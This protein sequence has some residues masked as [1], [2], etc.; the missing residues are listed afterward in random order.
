MDLELDDFV[1]YRLSVASNA[2]SL[3]IA[4]AYEKRF[5]LKMI[6]WRVMAILAN[7]AGLT[8]QELVGRTRMDKVTVSRAAQGLEERGLVRRAPNEEDGR[9]LRLSLTAA[10]QKLHARVSP[11]AVS[12]EAEILAS[13][14]AKEIAALKTVL[15]RIEAAATTI[16]DAG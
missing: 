12:L 5:D 9:S 6:E 16:L 7:G 10:G 3:A 4:R 14:S 2:V 15:R 11:I 1:P 13:L 8:Q